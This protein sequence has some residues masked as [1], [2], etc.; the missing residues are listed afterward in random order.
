MIVTLAGG[1]GLY[2]LTL[3]PLIWLTILMSMVI[4]DMVSTARGMS[5]EE[6]AEQLKKDPLV[7]VTLLCVTLTAIGLVISMVTILQNNITV[8]G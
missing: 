6:F 3:P 8:I 5:D 4:V 2:L 1:V 7:A